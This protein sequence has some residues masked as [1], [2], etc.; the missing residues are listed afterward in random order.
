[1]LLLQVTPNIGIS[2]LRGA[3]LSRGIVMQRQRIMDSMQRVDPVNRSLW[4]NCRIQRRRYSVPGPNSL[5]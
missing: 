3:L 2:M 4:R 5:W 1:M